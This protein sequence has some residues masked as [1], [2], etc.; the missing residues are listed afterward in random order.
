MVRIESAQNSFITYALP[1]T[2]SNNEIQTS[3]IEF[4]WGTFSQ[5][6]DHFNAS[7]TKYFKQVN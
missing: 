6:L 3:D 2:D 1:D 7:S 4:V 5:K